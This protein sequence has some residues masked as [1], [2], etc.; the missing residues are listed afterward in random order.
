MAREKKRVRDSYTEQVQIVMSSHLNGYGRAFGG[1]ILQWIDVIFGVVSRR[2]SGHEVTTAAIDHLEFLAP[3][4]LNETIVLAGKVTW[5][6]RHAM[7][8]RVDTF[9]ESLSGER[10]LVN[11]A[12]AVMVALDENE[13]PA[14]VPELILETDEERREFAAGAARQAERKARK[15]AERATLS[16]IRQ[17]SPPLQ[18]AK[19]G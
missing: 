9:V 19:E 6:G 5:V 1:M 7:E 17:P 2:H 3:A 11:V 4:H 8:V 16:A 13:R 10:K 15:W 14:L 18:G 12:Y